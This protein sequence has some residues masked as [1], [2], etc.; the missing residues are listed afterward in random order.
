LALR[1]PKNS[2]KVRLVDAMVREVSAEVIVP[3]TTVE[4]SIMSCVVDRGIVR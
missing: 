1:V 4:V 2:R 3:D